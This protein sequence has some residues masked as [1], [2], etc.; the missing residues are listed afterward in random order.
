MNS[1]TSFA[2]RLLHS[3][4]SLCG[5]EYRLDLSFDVF[6]SPQP[7][8]ATL[9]AIEFAAA[10]LS[11]VLAVANRIRQELNDYRRPFPSSYASASA[12]RRRWL[13]GGSLSNDVGAASSPSLASPSLWLC[14]VRTFCPFGPF[15]S[16]LAVRIACFVDSHSAGAH[17]PSLS[18]RFTGRPV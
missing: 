14:P 7:E 17:V 6:L 9:I 10:I 15:G 5:G 12:C 2:R 11:E 16:R 4:L 3:V 18:V 13:L 1:I 8:R